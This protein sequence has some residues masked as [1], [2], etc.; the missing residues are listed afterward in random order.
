MNKIS[1]RIFLKLIKATISFPVT[2]LCFA[3]YYLYSNHIDMEIW[4]ACAG[5]FLLSSASS[6]LNQ[7]IE[8]KYDAIMDR[9][10]N[11]PLPSG[12]I[13]TTT[14]IL[15]VI[16]L[17]ILGIGSL[18]V[19]SSTAALLGILAVA[20]YILVYTL[21]KRKTPFATI[22][23]ALIGALP[24]LI[25]WTAAGG[26]LTNIPILLTATF[27]F[28]WQIPHF[29][30]LMI[31]YGTDYEKAGFPTLYRI[32][33]AQNLKFWTMC[34]IITLAIFSFFF[35]PFEMVTSTAAKVILLLSNIGIIVLSSLYLISRRN[36][37]LK[38]LFH[39]LNL[40]ML[41]VVIIILFE[42]T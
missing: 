23:G 24:V 17:A 37:G 21:L 42:M 32:F 9:T 22:P 40:Y 6:A 28:L 2:F 11:R 26:S 10:K 31:V 1:L 20:W 33:S 8:Q 7:V 15:I 27:V 30:L 16:G 34:W 5:V 39:Y 35:V 41:T 29:W 36:F 14:A 4:L 13:T 18:R 38:N 25:G 3:G 19:L 12:K